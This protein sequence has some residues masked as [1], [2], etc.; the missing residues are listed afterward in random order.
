MRRAAEIAGHDPA[1]YRGEAMPSPLMPGRGED[2]IVFIHGPDDR[3]PIGAVGA[4]PATAKPAGPVPTT[5]A[6]G[7]VYLP[8]RA[9]DLKWETAFSARR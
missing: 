1:G 2:P 6:R 7:M 8:P 5:Q 4:Q 9:S 3:Q